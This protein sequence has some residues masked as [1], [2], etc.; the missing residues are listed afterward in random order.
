MSITLALGETTVTLPDPSPG[1]PVWAVKRQFLGR[2]AGGAIYAYDKGVQTFEVELP[3]ESLTDTEKTALA[4]FFAD[5]A[6]GGLRTFTYT[7]SNATAYTA[8]F[9]EP[10]LSFV[11][12][13]AKVWDVRLHLE[14]SSMGN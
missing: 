10:S 13:S 6:E 7:D 2:T 1:Y 8:R 12:V 14:L 9:L 11:K 5:T 3:F 4:D